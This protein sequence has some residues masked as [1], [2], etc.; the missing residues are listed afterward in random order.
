MSPSAQEAASMEDKPIGSTR[1][2][3]VL[4]TKE[5]ANAVIPR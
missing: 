1:S 4:C 2:A 5:I 3:I